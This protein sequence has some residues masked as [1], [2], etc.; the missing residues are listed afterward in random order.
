MT[1]LECSCN[2]EN[3]KCGKQ[4]KASS[5]SRPVSSGG[6]KVISEVLVNKWKSR[7]CHKAA[8]DKGAI[9]FFF[10]EITR[11]ALSL[12]HAQ[13]TTKS[14]KTHK[15]SQAGKWTLLLHFRVYSGH[16]IISHTFFLCSSLAWLPVVP[17][18][19]RTECTS[20]DSMAPS[21][22]KRFTRTHSS[23]SLC[24]RLFMGS[25]VAFL[26]AAVRKHSR[27]TWIEL[28]LMYF[29]QTRTAKATSGSNQMFLIILVSLKAHICFWSTLPF[30][31]W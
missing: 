24:D 21:H 25:R 2:T 14:P 23:I 22:V 29:K 30:Y 27:E 1:V 28:R 18:F 19:P 6:S 16:C 26:H 17:S 12:N 10:H 31:L 8:W 20:A 11:S 4:K 3:S 9:S 15:D 7:C 5:L 13:I